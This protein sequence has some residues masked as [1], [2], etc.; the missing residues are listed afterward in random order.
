MAEDTASKFVFQFKNIS[1][2]LDDSLNVMQQNYDLLS[3]L[4]DNVE[5]S[6]TQLTQTLETLTRAIR[7][8]EEIF[9]DQVDTLLNTFTFEIAN[10]KDIL[11]L[12]TF[13]KSKEAVEEILKLVYAELDPQKLRPM[14]RELVQASLKILTVATGSQQVKMELPPDEGGY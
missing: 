1:M 14:M 10:L 3:G 5:K 13:T 4:M 2:K 9:A 7:E 8:E 11:K 12:E 6:I